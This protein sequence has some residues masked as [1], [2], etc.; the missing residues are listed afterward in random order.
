MTISPPLILAKSQPGPPGSGCLEQVLFSTLAGPVLH[1]WQVKEWPLYDLFARPG[2]SVCFFTCITHSHSPVISPKLRLFPEL[3]DHPIS[4]CECVGR[5][6]YNC[7]HVF[8]YSEHRLSIIASGQGWWDQCCSS[9][10][11]I[12]STLYLTQKGFQPPIEAF[13]ITIIVCG[14]R[15]GLVKCTAG[16][17]PDL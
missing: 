4:E 14:A 5:S 11:Q 13:S 1:S 8:S 3:W 12:A 2:F 6:S 15:P 17:L 16:C 7:L 9:C 10:M